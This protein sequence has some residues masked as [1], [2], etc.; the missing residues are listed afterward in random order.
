M[1][2]NN[3]LVT[4]GEIDS[5][6]GKRPGYSLGSVSSSKCLTRNEI[7]NNYF[8]SCDS[9]TRM[10]LYNDLSL[11]KYI[12]FPVSNKTDSN[13]SFRIGWK[14]AGGTINYTDYQTIGA[15]SY[16]NFYIEGLE[17]DT[18]YYFYLYIDNGKKIYLLQ[19]NSLVNTLE[20]GGSFYC[21]PITEII[22]H[23]SWAI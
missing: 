16:K 19:N 4:R 1:L 5:W 7:V 13:F 17:K 22:R 6:S 3:Y 8:V 12:V 20:S 23:H 9:M 21:T 15:Y 14:K 10:P 11:I 18:V 2:A